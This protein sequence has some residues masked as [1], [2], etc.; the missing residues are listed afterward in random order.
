MIGNEDEWKESL[1]QTMLM[2]DGQV[3]R[4]VE[5]RGQDWRVVEEMQD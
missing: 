4:D 3:K 2:M 1:G 5:R